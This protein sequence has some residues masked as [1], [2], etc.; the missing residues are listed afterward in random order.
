ML[1]FLYSGSSFIW[2]TPKPVGKM[3]KP[4]SW[5]LSLDAKIHNIAPCINWNNF[6]FKYYPKCFQKFPFISEWNRL[7]PSALQRSMCH[8]RHLFLSW[9]CQ[10]L[11]WYFAVCLKR[12]LFVYLW[13]FDI[14]CRRRALPFK[15]NQLIS[16]YRLVVSSI[17]LIKWECF[18]L[19]IDCN[20]EK[21][22]KKKQIEKQTKLVCRVSVLNKWT[23]YDEYPRV[24]RSR[25]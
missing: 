6:F 11:V 23:A 19:L 15:L 9:I 18:I 4:L 3:F 16:V 14:F 7:K 2:Q 5:M 20:K 25:R 17:A 21:Q 1:K 12:I 24:S 8:L 22:Q 10:K 13:V